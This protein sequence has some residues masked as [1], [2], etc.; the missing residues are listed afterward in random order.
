MTSL[1]IGSC[2]WKYPSW[3]GLV[4]SKAGSINYLKEYADQFNSVE[5]DQWFW[6]L[7][8]ENK[9][10]LPDPAIVREYGQAVPADFKFIVKV[11]NSIT[12]THFYTRGK[13]L[14]LTANPHF[15]STDLFKQFLQRIEPLGKNLGP[16][17]FQFEYLNKKKIPSQNYFMERL[18]EFFSQL[19]RGYIYAI[20]VRNPNYLNESFFEFLR[21]HQLYFVFMHGYYMPSIFDVFQSFSDYIQGLTVIRLMGS[22][23]QKIETAAGKQ[24]DKVVVARE[25]ELDRLIPMIE[26]LRQ[27]RVEVYLNIN[28]HF[29]G[30]APL[31]IGRIRQ[32]MGEK[33][34]SNFKVNI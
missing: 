5:I 24:W 18:G 31:T 7:F 8:G 26:E 28:N 29:E 27:Q 12:L 22:D 17:I 34:R 1:Y 20:E 14:P 2:S 30:S 3:Q 10:K 16:L 25:E 11:P 21:F 4:Y 33:I 23:R 19:P 13:N 9:V 15:F 6:S 32:R